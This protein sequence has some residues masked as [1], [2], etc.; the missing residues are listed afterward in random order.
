MALQ[1]CLHKKDSDFS[2]PKWLTK[3]IATAVTMNKW[4]RFYCACSKIIAS[5][6]HMTDAK[7]D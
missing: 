1:K 6:S 4:P 3:Y 7:S 5:L 2:L